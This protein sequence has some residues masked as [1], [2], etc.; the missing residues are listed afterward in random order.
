MPTDDLFTG[1]LPFVRTAEA[2][3]FRRAAE[4]LGVTTAAI[5][6]AVAK[7]EERL[8]AKLL[9]RTSRSVA[10]T[11]EGRA[12]LE[13]CRE[14]VDSLLAGREQL[15]QAASQP[16][17][18][19]RLTL[20]PILGRIVVPALP[21]LASR[22]PNLRVRLTNT[23]RVSR[24]G[25]EHLDLAIRIGHHEDSSLV[26]RTLHRPRWVTVASPGYL[27][28]HG[29]PQA[30]EDL[31]RHACLR[32]V[33][34]SGKPTAWTFSGREG[35][36]AVDGPLTSDHGEQLVDA[37]VAGLGVAQAMSFMV[38][39]PLRDG[40]LVQV[41]DGFE[42]EAP[43]VHAVSTPERAKTPNVRACVAFLADLFAAI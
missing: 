31:A 42:A 13:R 20:S 7:L 35:T 2:Q 17:G 8:G 37:A 34:P 5:S 25:S 26:S 21:R 4:E 16:R 38:H 3:S 27:A 41:L 30:P 14:A 18:E 1:V 40:R 43:T 23:D 33:G 10:L 39:E 6:K 24:L 36:L 28:R 11:P 32:F 15:E 29:A 9:V 22:Y 19:V 12:Y